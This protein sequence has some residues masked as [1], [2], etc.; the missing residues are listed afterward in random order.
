MERLNLDVKERREHK[1]RQTV[2]SWSRVKNPRTNNKAITVNLEHC[3]YPVIEEIAR[4]QGWVV[5]R[6]SSESWDLLWTD[7]VSGAN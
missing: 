4:K 3:K 6:D 7:T 1:I 5:S 2:S